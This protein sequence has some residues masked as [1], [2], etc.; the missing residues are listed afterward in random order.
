MKFIETTNWVLGELGAT[1]EET[2]V[3]SGRTC[4]AE[5]QSKIDT[6]E[7]IAEKMNE[8]GFTC[9]KFQFGRPY[10]GAPLLNEKTGECTPIQK[11][12]K[13]VCNDINFPDKNRALCFCEGFKKEY[14]LSNLTF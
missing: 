6:E 14:L 7:L 10:A 8:A 3:K 1:C 11:G 4:N 12:F 13:S 2:C 5:E 9:V